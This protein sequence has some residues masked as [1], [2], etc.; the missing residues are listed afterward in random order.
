MNPQYPDEKKS[1]FIETKFLESNN[2][3][4]VLATRLVENITTQE[5]PHS[6]PNPAIGNLLLN[7]FLV[8]KVLGEG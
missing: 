2:S 7:R 6:P 4:D 8:L 1:D 3:E 5:S